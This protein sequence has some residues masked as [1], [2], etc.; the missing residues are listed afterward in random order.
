MKILSQFGRGLRQAVRWVFREKPANQLLPFEEVRRSLEAVQE[1]RLGYRVVPLDR[2]IGSVGRYKDFNAEFHVEEHLDRGRL[3]K[4]KDLMQREE[5]LPPVKLYKI[6]DAYFVLDGNHRIAAAKEL[7]KEFVDAEVTECVVPIPFQVGDEEP[8]DAILD[9]EYRLFLQ[10]TRLDRLRPRHPAIRFSTH[11]R[12]AVLLRHIEEH[13][14]FQG[15]ERKRAV[16]M[17]EAVIS[18]YDTIWTPMVLL[19]EKHG[20]LERFPGRTDGD[21]YIF[22]MNHRWMLSQEAGR[23]VGPEEAVLHFLVEGPCPAGV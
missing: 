17:D 14:Y 8:K 23:D 21:L 13:R 9:A 4:V 15:I 7:D 10:K 12:Y 18:W 5:P 11:G 2:I 20:I 16:S 6:G 1:R 19:I 3:S 22:V